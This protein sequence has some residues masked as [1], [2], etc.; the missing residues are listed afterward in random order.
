M[1]DNSL[2]PPIKAI[3]L[4]PQSMITITEEGLR[5]RVGDTLSVYKERSE[6]TAKL[7]GSVTFFVSVLLSF[8]SNVR[9]QK[10]CVS[11]QRLDCFFLVLPGLFAGCFT[12][13]CRATVQNKETRRSYFRHYQR[14]FKPSDSR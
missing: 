7:I 14:F 12:L 4:V 9:I 13:L 3:Y 11:L 8:F 2:T 5:L 1:K 6:L 10:F